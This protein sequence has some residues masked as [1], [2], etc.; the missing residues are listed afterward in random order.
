MKTLLLLPLL[1]LLLTGCVRV[2]MTTITVPTANGVVSI[3]APK[4]SK[5]TGLK[6]NFDK[7]TVQLDSYETRMNP[8]V[9]GASSV[10][11]VELIKAYAD[12]AQMGLRSFAAS[13]GVPLPVAPPQQ[14]QQPA[15]PSNLITPAQL[16]ALIQRRA[17][18]IANTRTSQEAV[19]IPPRSERSPV[20]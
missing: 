20:Q 17:E 8:D 18:E 5:I 4:D 15:Q 11:Q 14:P 7:G 1:L 10:G 2:P 3:K 19:P 9:I 16:D 13:Q 6:A 12:L